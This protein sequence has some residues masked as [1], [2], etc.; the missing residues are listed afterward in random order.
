MTPSLPERIKERLN[1]LGKSASAASMEAGLGKT[2][3][4]DILSGR[5]KSPQLATLVK[6][7]TP[8]DCTLAYLTGDS[9]KPDQGDAMEAEFNPRHEPL[10]DY[11]EAGV[12]RK[13][14]WENMDDPRR[15]AEGG[16]IYRDLRL[17]GWEFSLFKMKDNSMDL[18]NIIEGDVVTAAH[19]EL[20][21]KD[22]PLVP[23]RIV[24]V[25]Y[26]VAGIQAAETSLRLVTAENGK[27]RLVT[28]SSRGSEAP[29][30]LGHRITHEKRFNMYRANP[31]RVWIIG[32][33][34]RVTRELPLPMGENSL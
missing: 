8:L 11:I 16:L 30:E 6:L 34:V 31:G 25:R 33:A 21:K 23:G 1:A 22:I 13:A 9:D 3:I 14:L 17:I 12:F 19:G 26:T 24:V 7:A 32:T 5:A 15:E 2:A 29:I 20:N 27:V 18:L 10:M 4:R 28:R